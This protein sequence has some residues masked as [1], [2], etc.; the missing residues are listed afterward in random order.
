M[1][2]KL[3]AKSRVVFLD[4]ILYTGFMNEKKDRTEELLEALTSAV[5][6]IQTDITGMKTDI[7]GLKTDVKGLKE[8]VGELETTLVEYIGYQEGVNDE[9]RAA[10]RRILE[11]VGDENGLAD[12]HAKIANH[13]TRIRKL[14]LAAA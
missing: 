12:A 8:T 1:Q 13:D 14:E 2:A 11:L 5:Q 7:A 4:R 6:N 9:L 3:S 10:N